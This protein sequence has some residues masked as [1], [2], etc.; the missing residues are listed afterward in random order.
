M[1]VS[2]SVPAHT[3]SSK[4]KEPVGILLCEACKIEAFRRF[5]DE[6]RLRT[7]TALKPKKIHP[8]QDVKS[9]GAGW[10]D[11]ALCKR[12]EDK[13]SREQAIKA[14]VL[15]HCSQ[16]SF[17]KSRKIVSKSWFREV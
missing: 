4:G 9:E 16:D 17:P 15:Q 10:V 3:C 14:A 6:A 11:A 12:S 8:V 5:E 7:R 13:L 1:G 2:A